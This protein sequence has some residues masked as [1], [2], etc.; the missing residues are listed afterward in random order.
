M[1][2]RRVTNSH[3][4]NRLCIPPLNYHP[5]MRAPR[6][7]AMMA[8]IVCSLLSGCSP[9]TIWRTELKSPDG[10]WLAIA[11]TEQNGGFGSASINTIVALK[12]IDGTI[13][14]GKP[15]NVIDFDCPGPAAHAYVMDQAN[16]GGTIHLVITWLTPSHL[17]ITYDGKANLIFQ[18][19][20]LANL[21]ISVQDTSK[22]TTSDAH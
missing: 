4:T 8:V 3:G 18:V 9:P 16:A 13:N 11:H 20:R 22:T 21:D 7:L 19:A 5:C 1:V 2:R 14:S 10:A 17:Q 6:T 12:R 15:Q